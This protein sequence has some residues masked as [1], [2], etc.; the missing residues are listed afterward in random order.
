LATIPDTW[1]PTW[2][3]VTAEIVPVAATVS[4]TDPTSAASVRYFGSDLPF[5]RFM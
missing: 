4:A 5:S 2:T 3:V 1:L